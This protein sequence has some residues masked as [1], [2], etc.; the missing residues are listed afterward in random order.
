MR[1]ILSAI[2]I[3]L[4]AA[5]PLR[6]PP[7]PTAWRDGVLLWAY[8]YDISP[9]LAGQIASA[10]DRHQIDRGFAFRLV[11]RESGFRIRARG[12]AGEIGLTQIKLGTARDFRRGI[13]AIQLYQP[14]TNLDLGF[15]YTARLRARYRG[16]L[17]RTATAYSHGPAVADRIRGATRYSIEVAGGGRR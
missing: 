15:R 16:D 12:A 17:H 5:P 3:A 7:A 1:I 2:A 4:A 10:A 13:T 8:R 11:R 9:T 6:A 14:G